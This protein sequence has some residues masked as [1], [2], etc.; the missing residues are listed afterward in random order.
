VERAAAQHT[1]LVT[2]GLQILSLGPTLYVRRIGVI[3]SNTSRPLPHITTQIFNAIGYAR[4]TWK[5]AYRTGGVDAGISII[6]TVGMG[7]IG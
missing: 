7:L 5:A 2:S 1:G 6:R 3:L 4:P